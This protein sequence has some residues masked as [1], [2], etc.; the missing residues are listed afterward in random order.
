MGLAKNY[1]DK[2]H[3]IDPKA[4]LASYDYDLKLAF[5][6]NKVLSNAQVMDVLL[7]HYQPSSSGSVQVKRSS[8]LI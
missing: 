7:V 4:N 2:V 5:P 1:M 8:K 3:F 6:N